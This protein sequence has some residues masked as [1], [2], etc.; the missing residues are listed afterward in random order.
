MFTRIY[1]AVLHWLRCVNDHSLH[2]PFLFNI[3]KNL[4]RRKYRDSDSID[5]YL[6]SLKTNES[7]LLIDDYGVGSS[8]LKSNS[9]RIKDIA[10]T[11]T[12]SL[13]IRKIIRNYIFQNQPKCIIELGTNLGVTT[14]LMAESSLDYGGQV[15]SFEG[16]NALAELAERSFKDFNL[17]NI[18]IIKGDLDSTLDTTLATLDDKIDFVYMDANHTYEATINYLNLIYPY[19]N[20]NAAILIGDIYWSK[21]MKKAWK[22]ICSSGMFNTK[23]DFYHSGLI[24]KGPNI[25]EE[26]EILMSR[27]L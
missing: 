23:L 12:S 1:N 27:P 8:T 10:K 7:I 2:S 11:S 9:R 22:E 24:L 20:E 6:S 13:S 14:M 16:S 21:S 3:Y 26:H 5:N 25:P 18:K 15:Y 19:L 4:I 17:G